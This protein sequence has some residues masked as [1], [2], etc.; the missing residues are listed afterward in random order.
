MTKK[1]KIVKRICSALWWLLVVSLVILLV[2]VLGAKMQGKVP[3]LCGYSVLHIITGSMED[4]IPTGSYILVKKTAPEDVQKEDI[5]SFYSEERAIYGL[6]NTHRVKDIV[7]GDKGLEF[8]TKGD[9]NPSNDTVNAKEEK[10]IGVY[11]MSLD[12]I[13]NFDSFLTNGGM[14]WIII[15]LWIMMLVLVTL[16]TFKKMKMKELRPEDTEGDPNSADGGEKPSENT[17]EEGQYRE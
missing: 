6:P 4:T 13:T 5:I 2:T 3:S 10:L 16:M 15:V 9:A 8:V 12:I 1:A 14:I 11:V 7:Q 17:R